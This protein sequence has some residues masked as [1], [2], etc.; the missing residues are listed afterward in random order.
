MLRFFFFFFYSSIKINSFIL[1]KGARNH[2]FYN[3]SFRYTE[4][5]FSERG[6]MTIWGMFSWTIYI[7][8]HA[9]LDLK[10]HDLVLHLCVNRKIMPSCCIWDIYQGNKYYMVS[11]R[12][13]ETISVIKEWCYNLYISKSIFHFYFYFTVFKLCLTL[14]RRGF[15]HTLCWILLYCGL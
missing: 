9:K 7:I 3:V 14:S 11:P 1:K 6:I 12:I 5:I 4:Y 13:S 2:L 10:D 8:V 15:F